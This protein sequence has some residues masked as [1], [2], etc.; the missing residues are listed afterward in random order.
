MASGHWSRCGWQSFSSS[1]HFGAALILV[2]ALLLVR[3]DFPRVLVVYG[4]AVGALDLFVVPT[5]RFVLTAFPL[6]AVVGR[7]LKGGWYW[8]A[9]T[10]CGMGLAGV[11]VLTLLGKTTP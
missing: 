9:L 11:L 7:R 2:S 5:P 1:D 10:G 8:V 4:L 3:S 6:V